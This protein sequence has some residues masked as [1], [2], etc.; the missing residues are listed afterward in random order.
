LTLVIDAS[1]ACKWFIAETL[2]DHA[3]ALL[4]NPSA[5]IAPDLI[6]PEVCNLAR[7]KLRHGEITPEQATVMVDELPELLD[8][9][10]PCAQL[11]ARAL[12][13]ARA[14]DHAAYDCFYVALA[15]ARDARLVT[16]DR[17]LRS[18]LAATRWAGLLVGLGEAV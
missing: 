15:E 16:A 17:G 3:E 18:K 7:T 11:A 12:A 4:L 2:S 5:R 13:I 14:V 8:E 9:L 1:V 10:V 6:V